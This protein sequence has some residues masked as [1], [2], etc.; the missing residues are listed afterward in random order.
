MGQVGTLNLLVLVRIRAGPSSQG[1][2]WV[3]GIPRLI[4]KP[5]AQHG[6]RRTT[7]TNNARVSDEKIRVG[8]H[9]TGLLR[10]RNQRVVGSSPTAGSRNSNKFGGA[11]GFGGVRNIFVSHP[12]NAQTGRSF[13]YQLNRT[14]A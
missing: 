9:R 14:V 4:P 10:L 6:H 13:A 12:S 8:R 7:W 5:S 11:R 2:R 1:H 3:L